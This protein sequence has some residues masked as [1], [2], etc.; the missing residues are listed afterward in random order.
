MWPFKKK[1]DWYELVCASERE[2]YEKTG[3]SHWNG[4]SHYIRMCMMS[5]GVEF[6]CY[7]REQKYWN[8]QNNK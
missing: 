2:V 3:I 6:P 5:E 7:E 1:V 8:N 4:F